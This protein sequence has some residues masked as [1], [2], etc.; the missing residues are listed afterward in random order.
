MSRAAESEP[1][2]RDQLEQYL[3]RRAEDGEFYFKSK[4][5][6]GDVGLSTKE[7][8]ALIPELRQSASTLRI[9]EW[10]YANATTWR[11]A[12]A[13]DVTPASD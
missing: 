7:I 11:V 4:F 2:K 5:I 9:E 3:R 6:A 10:G 8:G 12:P 1:S 13:G